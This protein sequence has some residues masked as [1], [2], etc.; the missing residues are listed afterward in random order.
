M[1]SQITMD[2]I[3][4]LIAVS[5]AVI[6]VYCVYRVGLVEQ[7][8][9]I[10]VEEAAKG[11]RAHIDAELEPLQK[12]VNRAFGFKA[13]ASHDSRALKKAE[14]MIIQDV[15]DTQDPVLMGVLDMVSPATK[16]YLEEHPS[17]IVELI[18]RLQALS[19][20]EGFSILD[21]LKPPGDGVHRGKHPF[22][23]REE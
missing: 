4:V 7:G 19:Q 17:L 6:A 13:Q 16:E 20:V 2:M 12:N 22:G 8:L 11:L 18:P 10:E 5:S 1:L 23:N 21:L 14:G 9:V 15:L 3:S